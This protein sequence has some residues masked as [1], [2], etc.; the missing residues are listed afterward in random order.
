M[1]GTCNF[2]WIHSLS[3]I[4]FFE[5][6]ENLVLSNELK[7]NSKIVSWCWFSWGCGRA[8]PLLEMW[9]HAFV[10][11]FMKW[12]VFIDSM[13]IEINFC[14]SFLLLY[15]FPWFEDKLKIV[16]LWWEWLGRRRWHTTGFDIQYLCRFFPTSHRCLWKRS[17]NTN[18]V[19]SL[20]GLCRSSC[21]VQV[22]QWIT[23][24]WEGPKTPT[25]V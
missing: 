9:W 12:E 8:F 5:K 16:L 15:V 6:H 20:F 23:F 21:S 7:V 18:T 19:F 11:N 17:A 4:F 22:I 1:L 25:K 24:T 3:Q 13:W 10:N 2:L 14:S